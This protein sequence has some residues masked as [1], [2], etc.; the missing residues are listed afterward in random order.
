MCAQMDK[1]P[2]F[3]PLE[4][5]D[6]FDGFLF[7]FEISLELNPDNTNA[8]KMLDKLK[9]REMHFGILFAS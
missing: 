2:I 6:F 3:L 7:D 9:K 5:V 1:E 8:L 4:W